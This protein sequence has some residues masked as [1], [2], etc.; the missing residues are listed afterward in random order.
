MLKL[1]TIQTFHKTST[2]W[3]SQR[4]S[5]LGFLQNLHYVGISHKY[6]VG[7]LER[8]IVSHS[9]Y[10]SGILERTTFVSHKHNLSSSQDNHNLGTSKDKYSRSKDKLNICIS[11]D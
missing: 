3:A 10:N 7:I 2:V 5:S 4:T 11:P 1:W 6:N 8:A 9:K